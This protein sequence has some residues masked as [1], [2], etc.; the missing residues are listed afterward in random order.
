MSMFGNK[1]KAERAV[2]NSD[3]SQITTLIGE[4]CIFEGNVT[5]TSSTRIDGQLKGKITGQ[6]SL[7]VGESGVVLGEIK[8]AET[9]VYG[10]VEGIIESCKLEIKSTGSVVG[11]LFIEKLTVDD[12]G[13][14]NGRCVMNES[15]ES[16]LVETNG[17]STKELPLSTIDVDE[18][19]SFE[20]SKEDE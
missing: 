10:R 3:A 4:S 11:D 17:P 14:Y 9:I 16:I 20:A 6:Y 1:K 18:T 19:S 5:T 8:A 12:G 15:Q 2:S 13:T 7:I